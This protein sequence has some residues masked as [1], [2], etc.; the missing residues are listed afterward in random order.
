MAPNE[1]GSCSV[2]LTLRW[3]CICE[4]YCRSTASAKKIR[5]EADSDS[6]VCYEDVIEEAQEMELQYGVSWKYMGSKAQASGQAMILATQA[7]VLSYYV[8]VCKWPAVRY[9]ERDSA[10]CKKYQVM[11]PLAVGKRMGQLERQVLAVCKAASALCDNKSDGG[12]MCHAESVKFLYICLR[13]PLRD[14]DGNL[15]ATAS[16]ASGGR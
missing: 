6:E 15:C 10:H 8:G 14:S 7:S 16:A 4:D 1:R 5:R 11:Y 13:L 12:E 9:Y 3:E 2:C